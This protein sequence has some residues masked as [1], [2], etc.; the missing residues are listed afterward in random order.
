MDVPD[1]FVKELIPLLME[2]ND[3][4][5]DEHHEYWSVDGADDTRIAAS[6]FV[7]GMI[8]S[9]KVFIAT[10]SVLRED[11]KD[12]QLFRVLRGRISD[13]F[14]RWLEDNAAR[15]KEVSSSG[16]IADAMEK[17]GRL[18]EAEA[19]RHVS[20]QLSEVMQASKDNT[21]RLREEFRSSVRD[22]LNAVQDLGQSV[23]TA[24]A[25]AG[26]APGPAVPGPAS[27]P[28]R[29]EIPSGGVYMLAPAHARVCHS[30]ALIHTGGVSESVEGGARTRTGGINIADLPHD[31]NSARA[32]I[33]SLD[34]FDQYDPISRKGNGCT[35]LVKWMYS[36]GLSILEQFGDH[37]WTQCVDLSQKDRRNILA[38]RYSR[39]NE[40]WKRIVAKADAQIPQGASRGSDQMRKIRLEAAA[41]MDIEREVSSQGT[42]VGLSAWLDREIAAET[43]MSAAQKYQGSLQQ[44]CCASSTPEWKG[45]MSKAMRDLDAVISTV[46][47]RMCVHARTHIHTYVRAH[48]HTYT[49]ARAHART[50]THTHTHTRTHARTHALAGAHDGL[51]SQPSLPQPPLLSPFPT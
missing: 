18:A 14:E 44:A 34:D 38:K 17:S 42:E 49:R 45:R 16:A 36:R 29:S 10:M 46:E 24:G 33:P 19:F 50:H 25:F 48:I 35:S 2:W 27:G 3:A 5:C 9:V 1:E 31:S 20:T 7:E 15:Y 21:D 47:K 28:G 12:N 22:V 41:S 32:F 13:R 8:L 40:L 11:C 37:F 23:S 4:I 26:G 43:T 39:I 6:N 51:P 30:H